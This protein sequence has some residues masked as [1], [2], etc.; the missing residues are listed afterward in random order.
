MVVIHKISDF[1]GAWKVVNT[2]HIMNC[3]ISSSTQLTCNV[4][5]KVTFDVA[6]GEIIWGSGT[7]GTRDGNTIRWSDSDIWIKQGATKTLNFPTFS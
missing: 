3:D 4:Y 6:A 7:Y 5:Q 2:G 1:V